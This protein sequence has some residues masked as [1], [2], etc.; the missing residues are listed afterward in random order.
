MKD[1]AGPVG[2]TVVP[3]SITF[4]GSAEVSLK[5]RDLDC[6]LRAGI[7]RPV[8]VGLK[9]LVEYRLTEEGRILL[10]SLEPKK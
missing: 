4:T 3:P 2:R 1:L 7:I 10:A 8:R 5:Q 6:A 9:R